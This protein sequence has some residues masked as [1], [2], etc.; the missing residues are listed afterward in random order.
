LIV[1]FVLYDISSNVELELVNVDCSDQQCTKVLDG[2]LGKLQLWSRGANS[3][4]QYSFLSPIPPSK[5]DT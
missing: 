2:A 5:C 4:P 1:S 3:R